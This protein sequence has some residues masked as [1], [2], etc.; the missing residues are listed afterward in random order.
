MVWWPGIAIT[1]NPLSSQ[2]SCKFMFNLLFRLYFLCFI[3]C[4]FIFL[5]KY[6]NF[7]SKVNK[8]TQNISRN[9]IHTDKTD[10]FENESNWKRNQNVS[11]QILVSFEITCIFEIILFPFGFLRYFLLI[12][13][14]LLTKKGKLP[15]QHRQIQFSQMTSNLSFC[16][17]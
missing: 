14:K 13:I 7:K 16:Q 15:C 6:F 5:Q 10:C 8:S 2:V 17:F 3:Y 4:H 9:K 11:P 12:W 1:K